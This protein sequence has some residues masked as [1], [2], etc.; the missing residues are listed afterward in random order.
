MI[1]RK[2][3][4]KAIEW[5]EPYPNLAGDGKEGEIEVRQLFESEWPDY[6]GADCPGVARRDLKAFA[7]RGCLPVGVVAFRGGQV[8]AVAALKA[9]SFASHGRL[10]PWAAA[11]FVRSSERGRG[12]GTQLLAALEREAC[13]LGFQRVYCGTNTA[14]TLLRH[15]G[16]QLMKRIVHERQELAQIP[17]QLNWRFFVQNQLINF[18][19]DGGNPV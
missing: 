18:R 3:T 15:L 17:A 11:G 14:E 10:S 13:R 7:N 9:E 16:W 6:Y 12:I 1:D 5:A 8:C 2:T 4:E 19:G